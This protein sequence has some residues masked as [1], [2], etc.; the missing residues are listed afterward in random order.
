MA[1]ARKNKADYDQDLPVNAEWYTLEQACV[2]LGVHRQTFAKYR[3][4]GMIQVSQMGQA[5]RVRKSDLDAFME[6]LPRL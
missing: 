5:I 4:K 1:Y 3:K 2:A 6:N